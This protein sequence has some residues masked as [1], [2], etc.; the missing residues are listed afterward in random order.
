M[1]TSLPSTRRWMWPSSPWMRVVVWLTILAP[2]RPRRSSAPSLTVW[3]LRGVTIV[4]LAGLLGRGA[5]GAAVVPGAAD[6]P[7][8]PPEQ[9]ARPR[10]ARASR[11][12]ARARRRGRASL[13]GR[14][15]RRFMVVPLSDDLLEPAAALGAGGGGLD[16]ERYPAGFEVDVGGE[17]AGAEADQGQGLGPARGAGHGGAGLVGGLFVAALVEVGE[18]DGVGAGAAGVDVG[19]KG[20]AGG[21]GDGVEGGL[22]GGLGDLD[23]LGGGSGL[24]LQGNGDRRARALDQ[25]DHGP[26]AGDRQL[27]PL[28]LPEAVLAPGQLQGGCADVGVPTGGEPQG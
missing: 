5:A 18:V 2:S 9:A 24:E 7:L 19:L 10:T 25:A 6:P 8:S 23:G 28:P 20:A 14:G 3:P 21:Q 26:G 4:S 12:A 27:A 1:F 11:V 22:A 16:G 13:G 17:V 15:R